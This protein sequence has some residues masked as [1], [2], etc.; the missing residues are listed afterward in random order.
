M[1]CPITQSDHNKPEE[2]RVKRHLEAVSCDDAHVS[3]YPVAKLHLDDVP[4]HQFL[5]VNIQLLSVTHHDRKLHRI[6]RTPASRT[7]LAGK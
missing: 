3:R 6:T 7:E 4:D 1:V 2:I 5:R